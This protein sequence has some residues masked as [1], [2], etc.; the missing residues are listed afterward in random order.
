MG[1]RRA[2]D[3]LIASARELPGGDDPMTQAAI[4]IIGLRM[5]AADGEASATDRL[6][7]ELGRAAFPKPVLLFS[8]PYPPTP[9]AREEGIPR[10]GQ[11]RLASASDFAGLVGDTVR[12]SDIAMIQWADIG[13]WIRPDGSVAEAEVLRGSRERGWTEPYLHQVSRR[14]YSVTPGTVDGLGSY[15]VERFTL[16]GEYLTPPGSMIRLRGGPADLQ[17]IDVT[18]PGARV[19]AALSRSAT[20]SGCIA[21][22]LMLAARSPWPGCAITHAPATSTL[23]SRRNPIAW[24]HPAALAAAT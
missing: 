19:T 7:E 6:V 9:L 1:E 13:F 2:A 14:R 15:R 12:A 17:I 22:P 11:V 8:P 4:R 18:E 24:R 10:L 3:A 20:R 16:R 5:A 21:R 23:C